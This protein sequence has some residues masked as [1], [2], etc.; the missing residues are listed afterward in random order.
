M[1]P[2]WT[3][4]THDDGTMYSHKLNKTRAS[5][6]YDKNSYQLIHQENNECVLDLSMPKSHRIN[7]SFE[8]LNDDCRKTNVDSTFFID[9]EY[10]FES[11]SSDLL[12]FS[13][14]HE[15]FGS[16]GLI[17]YEQN[18]CDISTTQNSNLNEVTETYQ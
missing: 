2:P 6:K 5:S 12:S 13:S 11:S 16:N 18:S 15:S 8:G 10:N 1:F 4:T 17:N 7:E 3:T 9:I 14:G